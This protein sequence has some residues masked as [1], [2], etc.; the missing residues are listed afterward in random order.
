LFP[1]VL[2]ALVDREIEI[3]HDLAQRVLVHE[4]MLNT[5]SDIIGELDWYA[6]EVALPDTRLTS[7]VF[8]HSLKV[9]ESI[10]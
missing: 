9:L 5:I 6:F 1:K 3:V 10:A 8:V 2:I 4:E 7:L